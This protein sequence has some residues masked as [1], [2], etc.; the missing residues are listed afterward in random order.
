MPKLIIQIPCFNEQDTL[1]VTLAALPRSIPG[2]DRVDVLIINDGS[3][4]DTAAVARE[5]GVEH[6]L[7]IKVNRGLAHGFMAG[8]RQA[9]LLGAD[10]VVNLDAD[11]QY[12]ADDIPKLLEPLMQGRADMAVGERPIRDMEHF[13]ATKKSLQTLGSW[14]VRKLSGTS[15]K[16]TPSG[17][18]A[19]NRNALLNLFIFNEY[20]YTHESLIAAR[21]AGLRVIGVPIRV[22]TGQLRPSRLMR[23]TFEY[24]V[25]S[26]GTVLR[27]Y[28][29]YNSGRFFLSIAVVFLVPGILLIGRFFYFFF[30][31]QG[32]GWVQSLVIAS[33]LIGVGVLCL[34]MAVVGDMLKVNRKLM[35]K[36]LSELREHMALHHDHESGNDS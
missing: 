32:D 14:I 27:F 24:V 20:T 22:N 3:T 7:D 10:Y 8:L 4:D 6:I 33:V 19:M 2:V 25:R 1:P 23:S 30:T 16:D 18:R 28:F 21:E 17:F 9:L 29:L 11:N 12:N 35:Q 13:S 34:I 31:G 5:H 26:A 36:T 15:V